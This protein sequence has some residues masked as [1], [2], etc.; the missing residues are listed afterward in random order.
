[1]LHVSWREMLDV[2]PSGMFDVSLC[3]MLPRWENTTSENRSQISVHRT[4]KRRHFRNS[5][6]CHCSEHEQKTCLE[7]IQIVASFGRFRLSLAR[8]WPT[9]GKFGPGSANSGPNSAEIRSTSA[10]I[11]RG[12]P[13][14]G[15]S[16]FG[17]DQGWV[18][19]AR[20]PNLARSL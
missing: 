18:G 3:G 9:P 15:Q 10:K 20:C 11:H 19:F 13:G 1:M 12:F 16:W 8:N 6:S 2:S 17:I 5:E 14:L 4:K 7:S